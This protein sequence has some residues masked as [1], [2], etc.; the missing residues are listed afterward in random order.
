MT[1]YYVPV[2]GGG[3]PLTGP[4]A[5]QDIARVRVALD[6]ANGLR[7]AAGNPTTKTMYL[8]SGPCAVDRDV[9][10]RVTRVHGQVLATQERGGSVTSDEQVIVGDDGTAALELVDEVDEID[11]HL[12]STVR[13]VAIPSRASLV[14]EAQLPARVRA[15]KERGRAV[16]ALE[17]AMGLRQR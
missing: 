4:A 13:G 3:A 17:R 10:G 12:G 9:D 11:D 5:L 8:V 1:R 2:T 16:Q 15:E 7:D 14:T 6:Q